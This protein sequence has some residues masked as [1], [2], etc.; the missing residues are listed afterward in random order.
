MAIY[1]YEVDHGKNH[2]SVHAGMVFNG[3][4]V[5]AVNFSSALVQLEKAEEALSEI[6]KISYDQSGI[7]KI[8]EKYYDNTNR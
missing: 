6:D 3:G 5:T 1:T 8:L 2:A 7:G 4:I